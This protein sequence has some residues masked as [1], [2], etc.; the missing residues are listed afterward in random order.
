MSFNSRREILFLYT[1][2]DANPNGDPLNQNHPRYDEDTEQALV[3]DVRIKRTIRDEWVRQS[4][5]VFVDGESKT[6]KTRF[7]EL[8]ALTGNS[9]GKEVLGACLDTRLFGVTFALGNESFS[10]T[11]PV[12][13]KWGRSLHAATFEF[14]QGT[15]AFA[16]KEESQQRSFRNEYKVPFALIAVYGIANQY[17]ARYTGASDQDLEELAS[18]LWTGT[19]NLITRSKTEHTARLYLEIKYKED[20]KGKIGSLDEKIRLLSRAGEKL[21]RDAQKALRG[22]N[23]VMLDVL[24]LVEAIKEN[25]EFIEQVKVIQNRQLILKGEDEFKGLSFLNLETR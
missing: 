7:E 1:V 19:D 18:A 5:T 14:I 21:D 4:K 25:Q 23:E 11:G 2:K 16:T 6:L 10:W 8:K 13:F 24:P 9:T 20:F 15:A 22:L 17:A 12:Q 3:S